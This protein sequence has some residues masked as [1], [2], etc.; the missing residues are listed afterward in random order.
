M[1]IITTNEHA[2]LGLKFNFFVSFLGFLI[3]ASFLSSS[4][5]N[6]KQSKHSARYFRSS[7]ILSAK[8]ELVLIEER[9]H[10]E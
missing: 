10:G 3:I 2:H 6:I 5:S 4:N 8:I 1:S 9:K 7:I